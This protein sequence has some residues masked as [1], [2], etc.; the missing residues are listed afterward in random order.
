MVQSSVTRSLSTSASTAADNSTAAPIG[1]PLAA[2]K[3]A[4]GKEA[5]RQWAKENGYSDECLVELPVQW[6]EQDANAHVN[7]A[8][9][10]RWL[11]TGRL[12]FMR[13]LG[14]HLSNPQAAKDLSGSGKGKGVILAR[15]TFDYRRPVMQPDNVLIAHKPMEVAARKLVLHGSVYSYAQQAV[16]GESDSIM[17]AYDY[18]ATKSCEWDP[19]LVRLLKERGA[20]HKQ[21]GGEAKL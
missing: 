10:F 18:D 20:E 6:G 14:S 21:K 2:E 19:E 7:N 1:N 11:E 8:V 16:V 3:Y 17:V 15:I 4:S 12:N 9:Y 13:T 5:A